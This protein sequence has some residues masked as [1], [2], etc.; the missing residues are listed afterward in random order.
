MAWKTF[1]SRDIDIIVILWLSNP[2]PWPKGQVNPLAHR[3]F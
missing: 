1:W 2:K 3:E